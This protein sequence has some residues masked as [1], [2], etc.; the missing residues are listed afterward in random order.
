MEKLLFFCFI[1]RLGHG[2]QWTLVK[3]PSRARKYSAAQAGQGPSYI[4]LGA[5][6]PSPG[7]PAPAAACGGDGCGEPTDAPAGGPARARA[8]AAVGGAEARAGVA[9]ENHSWTAGRAV[10]CGG[11]RS[12]EAHESVR[13]EATEVG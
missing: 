5:R 4:G 1:V 9:A 3:I 12:D 6:G 13:P 2:M 11:G 7:S 8:G 10:S